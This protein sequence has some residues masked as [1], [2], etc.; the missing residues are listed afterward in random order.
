M[1]EERNIPATKG[2]AT[3]TLT[4]SQVETWE[5]AGWTVEKPKKKKASKSNA[6]SQTTSQ[7]N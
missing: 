3:A 1:T 7:K 6:R 4:A 5:A 2:K